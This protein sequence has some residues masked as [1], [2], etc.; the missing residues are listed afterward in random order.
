MNTSFSLNVK[1][2]KF[3]IYIVIPFSCN[4]DESGIIKVI[5]LDT[6]YTVYVK[7]LDKTYIVGNDATLFPS[8]SIDDCW[9]ERALDDNVDINLYGDKNKILKSKLKMG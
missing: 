4:K 8:P 2:K 5:Y 3:G 6:Y 1:V 9:M 7:F